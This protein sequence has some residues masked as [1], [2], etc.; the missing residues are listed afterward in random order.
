VPDAFHGTAALFIEMA[1]AR[2]DEDATASTIHPQRF[3]QAAIGIDLTD[4]ARVG[5]R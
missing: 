5:F 3:R 2:R 1:D 4:A